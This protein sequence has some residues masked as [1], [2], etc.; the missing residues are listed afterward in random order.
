MNLQPNLV[1]IINTLVGQTI[2]YLGFRID[3]NIPIL[4]SY[5]ALD[6]EFAE[7]T[8][9]G[10]YYV[11]KYHL[12]VA[13][14]YWELSK[15]NVL[16]VNCYE[17]RSIVSTYIS[18]LQDK[19]LVGIKVDENT[20][21][22]KACFSENIELTIKYVDNHDMYNWIIEFPDEMVI[23]FGPQRKCWYENKYDIPA[24]VELEKDDE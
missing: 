14:C 6:I 2:T 20:L 9:N 18:V 1:P 24:W 19:K 17:E 3:H 5:N 23:Y 4:H 15:N 16:L 7:L 22:A 11:G 10:K 21:D 8:W 13:Y 12:G